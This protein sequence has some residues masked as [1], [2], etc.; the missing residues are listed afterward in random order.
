MQGE[1]R[2]QRGGNAGD[3]RRLQIVAVAE[4]LIAQK[5]FEGFRVREVAD[6]VGINIATLHYHF[7]SKEA[8]VAAVVDRIVGRLDQV[9]PLQESAN[10]DP[11]TH[12][13]RH[14]GVVLDQFDDNR[15]QFVVLNELNTRAVRDETVCETLAAS[16]IA[17]RE[18]L[19][20]ILRAGRDGGHFRAD[21]DPEAAATLVIGFLRSLLFHPAA[22]ADTA[23]R[24]ADELLRCLTPPPL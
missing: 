15:Q 2:Q 23:R 18:Y 24:A 17:W 13:S 7:P 22:S 11:R 1:R 19:V 5:G 9:P 8:L 3:Q 6:V 12:L 21:L 4:D 20:E 14:M 16:D 10:L